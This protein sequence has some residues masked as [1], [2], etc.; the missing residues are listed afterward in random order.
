MVEFAK[1]AALLATGILGAA[2]AFMIAGG[3]L[4][5]VAAYLFK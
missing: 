3:A 1:C 5:G 2:L 4:L